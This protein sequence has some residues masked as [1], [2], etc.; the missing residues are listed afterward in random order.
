MGRLAGATR[1]LPFV[2]QHLRH[3]RVRTGSTVVAMGLCVF[4][5]CVLRSVLAQL[6]AFI[7]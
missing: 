5:F 6:D 2:F 7:D 1:F 4:L 3:T